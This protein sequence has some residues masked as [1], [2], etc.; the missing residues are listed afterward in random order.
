MP[1]YPGQLWLI[2]QPEQR[3]SGSVEVSAERIEVSIHGQQIGAWSRSDVAFTDRE[4]HFEIE[5]GGEALGFAP[6]QPD[7]FR[8]YLVGGLA[9]LFEQARPSLATEATPDPVAR[10]WWR[11]WDR[12]S[13]TRWS[14][15]RP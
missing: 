3:D 15:T 2:D 4:Q 9:A 10:S 12:A 6:D 8:T 5:V 7:A 13:W 1:N 14:R 11:F